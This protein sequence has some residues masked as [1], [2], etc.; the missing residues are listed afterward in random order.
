MELHKALKHIVDTEGSEIIKDLRLVNILDDFKAF[1]QFPAFK[2]ILRSIIAE[3]Y[4]QKLN[5]IGKWDNRSIALV[6]NYIQHTGFIQDY[7]CFI[8]KSLALG[9]GWESITLNKDLEYKKSN[10][11]RNEIDKLI[12]NIH[13][14]IFSF[15]NKLKDISNVQLRISNQGHLELDFRL[16]MIDYFNLDDDRLHIECW[17]SKK[18]G[19]GNMEGNVI[20]YE[21]T[22]VQDIRFISSGYFNPLDYKLIHI[23]NDKISK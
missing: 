1:E 23:F 4:S 2:Y 8:F 10:G 16:T 9:L 15:N 22:K 14:D 17:D 6:N 21:N 7:V 12:Q 11:S 5:E 18:E 3:G 19:D 13:F 20:K